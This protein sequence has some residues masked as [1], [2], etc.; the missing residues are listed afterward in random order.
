MTLSVNEASF[1]TA[2]ISGCIC[3]QVNKYGLLASVSALG[4]LRYNCRSVI[5]K[6]ATRVAPDDER[7]DI[8]VI[9]DCLAFMAREDGKPMIMW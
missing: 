1:Y 2:E 9:L 3:R 4:G 6:L 5:E 8:I 7:K